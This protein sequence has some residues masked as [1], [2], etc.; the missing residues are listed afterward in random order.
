MGW[1]ISE[2]LRKDSVVAALQKAVSKY[3]ITADAIFHSDRGV[4]FACE[5][6]REILDRLGFR[7]S[8]SGTGNCYDNAPMESFFIPSGMNCCS[9]RLRILG[10]ILG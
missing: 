7:Q 8:M 5:E 6:F 10:T 4:Q 2:S 1:D 9:E 3:E